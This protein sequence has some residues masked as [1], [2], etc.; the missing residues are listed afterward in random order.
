MGCRQIIRRTR[1][2]LYGGVLAVETLF[3]IRDVYL[4]IETEWL[5]DCAPFTCLLVIGGVIESRYGLNSCV[6][7]LEGP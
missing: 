3:T 6:A 2:S 1:S 5:H 4:F 7:G